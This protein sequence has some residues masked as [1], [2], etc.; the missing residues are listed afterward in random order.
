MVP[1]RH[2][3][4]GSTPYSLPALLNGSP[5]TVLQYVNNGTQITAFSFLIL[6]IL[7]LKQSVY[8]G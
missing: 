7:V 5:L 2:A 8:S 1:N 4:N 6:V 3:I